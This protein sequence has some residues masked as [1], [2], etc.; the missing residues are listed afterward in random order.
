MLTLLC[1]G[2]F[3]ATAHADDKFAAMDTDKDNAVSYDEFRA[4]YPQ[5]QKTAFEAIDV[6]KDGTLSHEEWDMFR[7]RHQ[8]GKMGQ[9]GGMG[10]GM[11]G[12]PPAGDAHGAGKPLIT[13]PAQ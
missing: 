9:G 11:G 12:M 5:M 7:A 13:P 8:M 4:A 2:L 1:L 6:N 3:A 10:G